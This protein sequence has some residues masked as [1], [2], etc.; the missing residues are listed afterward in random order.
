MPLKYLYITNTQLHND[1]EPMSAIIWKYQSS[2]S[3]KSACIKYVYDNESKTWPN[4]KE[5]HY[6]LELCHKSMNCTKILS[7]TQTVTANT[8]YEM[9]IWEK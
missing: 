5:N 1:Y 7:N 6:N 3:L 8:T 9:P 2:T 4:T